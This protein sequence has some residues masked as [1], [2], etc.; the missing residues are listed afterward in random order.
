MKNVR[1]IM[2]ESTKFHLE[3]F[4]NEENMNFSRKN[5]QEIDPRENFVKS[6]ACLLPFCRE[7]PET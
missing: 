2:F 4:I 6:I 7:N 1:E 3:E 5:Y